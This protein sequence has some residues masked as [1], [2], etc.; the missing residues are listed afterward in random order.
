MLKK[1]WF[2]VVLWS[3][4]MV[5]GCSGKQKED[6]ECNVVSEVESSEMDVAEDLKYYTIG[7][8]QNVCCTIVLRLTRLRNN[9]IMDVC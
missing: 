5:S 1:V 8:S 3:V 7:K 9:H 4:L 2:I 6:V